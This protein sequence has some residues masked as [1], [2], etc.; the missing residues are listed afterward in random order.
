VKYLKQPN[1]Q[2]KK[3]IYSHQLYSSG[4]L[5]YSSILDYI[6][7]KVYFLRILIIICANH[8]FALFRLIH[9]Q[10][11]HLE[12]AVDIIMK[13]IAPSFVENHSK[14]K[15]NCNLGYL[16][17]PDSLVMMGLTFKEVF[18]KCLNLN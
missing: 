17:L 6:M 15:E 10:V 7:A 12:S 8:D 1:S 4:N 3:S 13:L 14:I 11:Y 5:F 9:T 2:T 16:R 18:Q